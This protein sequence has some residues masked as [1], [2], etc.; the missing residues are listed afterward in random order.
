MHVPVHQEHGPVWEHGV[1][2]LLAWGAPRKVLRRPAAADDPGRGWV[3]T[4][5]RGDEVQVRL[6][7]SEIV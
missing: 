5:V 3:V 1:Q 7:T 6:T 2:V 4:R